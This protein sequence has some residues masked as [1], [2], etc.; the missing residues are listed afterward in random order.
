M[1][2]EQ[3]N[4]D[5]L[6]PGDLTKAQSGQSEFAELVETEVE[7]TS[8][9]T[10]LFKDHSLCVNRSRLSG[11]MLRCRL[12]GDVVQVSTSTRSTSLP[13]PSSTDCQ[14]DLH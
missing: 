14:R 8:I 12:P 3:T 6:S 2:A 11:E 10:G 9:H 13:K 5:I 7:D 1:P 4:I